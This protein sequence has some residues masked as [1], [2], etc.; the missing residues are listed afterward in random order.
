MLSSEDLKALA[1]WS[2]GRDAV[3]VSPLLFLCVRHVR[4][5]VGLW[6]H[7]VNCVRAVGLVSLMVLN[8]LSVIMIPLQKV[9]DRHVGVF[10]QLVGW[11]FG[12]QFCHRLQWNL[13]LLIYYS[14]NCVHC[15]QSYVSLDIPELQG[16]L[17]MFSDSFKLF[18]KC[19]EIMMKSSYLH[20]TGGTRLCSSRWYSGYLFELWLQQVS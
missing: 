6:T 13:M 15:L 19:K 2:L 8:R 12:T 3:L 9:L 4:G 14:C 17:I 10:V 1:S 18:R 20:G 11:L 5:V 16:Y 7:Y